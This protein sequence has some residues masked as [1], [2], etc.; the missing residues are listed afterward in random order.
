MAV[1]LS[2]VEEGD[3]AVDGGADVG[4]AVLVVD[5]RAVAVAASRAAQ[6]DRGDLQ[7]AAAERARDHKCSHYLDA[8]EPVSAVIVLSCARAA[9]LDG[10][11][12]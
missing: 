2:G 8:P 1:H 6:P 10:Q 7:S 4:D 9:M 12:A 5:C 3:A 11:P